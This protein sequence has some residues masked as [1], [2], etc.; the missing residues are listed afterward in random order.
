MKIHLK[1]YYMLHFLI[2]NE[3][4]IKAVDFTEHRGFNGFKRLAPGD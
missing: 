2:N 3:S 1:V 4:D